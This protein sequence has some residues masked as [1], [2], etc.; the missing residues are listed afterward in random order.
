MKIKAEQLEQIASLLVSHYKKKEL[1]VGK[2]A[3]STIIKAYDA[4]LNITVSIGVSTY[5]EDGKKKEELV[6]KA[7]WALY[8]AKKQGRN[9]VCYRTTEQ[10]I[11]V[12]HAG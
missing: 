9:R 8:R 2:A 6:D 7:D 4:N 3:E 1:M 11:S 5:P 12:P 10:S